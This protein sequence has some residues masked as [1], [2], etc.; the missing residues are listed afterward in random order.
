MKGERM[1]R[2]KEEELGRGEARSGRD[3]R[4]E[5]DERQKMEC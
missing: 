1:G 3:G 5:R 4:G 2:R